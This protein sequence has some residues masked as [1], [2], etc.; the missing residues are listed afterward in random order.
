MTL[1]SGL[2]RARDRLRGE[3]TLQRFQGTLGRTSTVLIIGVPGTDPGTSQDPV[4]GVETRHLGRRSSLQWTVFS[5]EKT[6][7]DT[8]V[9][10]VSTEYPE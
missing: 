1:S 6:G 5:P 10:N 3:T 2:D 9:R 7:T 8:G 4:G